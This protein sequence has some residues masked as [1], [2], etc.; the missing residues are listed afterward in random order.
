VREH[1]RPR[2]TSRGD[3]SLILLCRA[4]SP[5]HPMAANRSTT[6]S[7]APVTDP[8]PM[9]D[10]P[11]TEATPTANPPVSPES[12]QGSPQS[13]IFES[14]YRTSSLKK[15][16]TSRQV[17]DRH[18]FEGPDSPRMERSPPARRS[19]TESI[20]SPS[21]PR[22]SLLNS[23]RQTQGVIKVHILETFLGIMPIRLFLQLSKRI[24]VSRRRI[25]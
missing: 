9:A 11:S 13:P 15:S 20:G 24:Y 19:S 16:S 3:P 21:H 12:I 10:L 22:N 6:S 7:V 4:L 5:I 23:T 17:G 14:P 2:S 25:I 1:G 18:P 8:K